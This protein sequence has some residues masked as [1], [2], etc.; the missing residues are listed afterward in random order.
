MKVLFYEL[1]LLITLCSIFQTC[2]K[3]EPMPTPVAEF[4]YDPLTTNFTAPTTIRFS[5]FSTN[6][7]SYYWDYS[8]G[9]STDK[10]LIVKFSLAGAYNITLK[11]T[12]SGGTDTKSKTYTI[13]SSVPNNP[14]T[15][16]FTYSPN[17]N[18]IAPAKITFTNTSQNADSYQWDFGDGTTSTDVNPV[19]EF[20]NSGTFRVKLTAS[21]KTAS[22]ESIADILVNMPDITVTSLPS[23]DNAITD[24]MAKYN[25]SGVSI[26]LVKDDKLVY[27]KGY[28]FADKSN[29][30]SV[31][32]DHLFRI[33]SLSKSVTSV[34]IFKLIEQGKLSLDATVFGKNGV[35]CTEY[36]TQPYSAGIESITIRHLLQHV[37][38][39]WG[40]SV[41][42]PMFE[43]AWLSY[44]QSQL[45]SVVLNTRPLNN[46][47]GS[48]YDY[49]NF[50][51]LIL[52]RVIEKV[53]GQTYRNYVRENILKPIGITTM[54]IGGDTEA[55]RL[56]NEVKYYDS[57]YSPYLM[58][59]NRMDAHG[60]W[61]ASAVDLAR[62]LVRV[63]GFTN[64]PDI[65]TSSSISQM[66]T[67][68]KANT[69]YACGWSVNS[70]NNWW[71]TG[72]L[73]GESAEWIRTNGNI[74]WVILVNQRS[75]DANYFNELDATFW[76]G[77]GGITQWPN[78][79]LF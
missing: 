48:K 23:V 12:G 41:N 68:S 36:G 35:L 7:D 18:L 29:N 26:A 16:S 33:A 21:S 40:N 9:S 53:I 66:T 77:I 42:D 54:E 5:N 11:A 43:S 28:G 79:D 4:D 30:I 60:G 76:K 32:T 67:P 8:G 2:T 73:P 22:S 50:G 46:T 1:L 47:S 44:S 10:D 17:Q 58:K 39:G 20:S 55:E 69:N 64:K 57:S 70:V 24:L 31:R 15:A 59:V 78:Q 62:L 6:A 72:S 71:H 25:L 13:V 49:S 45:I 51:Y 19:K 3:K 34:A 37:A 63:N 14:P 65:L 75:N 38:G 56:P 52:G 27:A 61:V 74:G